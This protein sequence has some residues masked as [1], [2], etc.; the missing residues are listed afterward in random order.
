MYL[1]GQVVH[2]TLIGDEALS[3]SDKDEHCALAQ[4]P[5]EVE[6]LRPAVH[7]M[8]LRAYVGVLVAHV[9]CDVRKCIVVG[10][11]FE[12]AVE[13][14]SDAA[15]MLYPLVEAHL[16]LGILRYGND[17]AADGAWRDDA[18]DGHHLAVGAAEH[19]VDDVA[20]R[21]LGHS[22]GAV[23]KVDDDL[24]AV[25]LLDGMYDAACHVGA[26]A[27]DGG[28]VHV[29]RRRNALGLFEQHLALALLVAAVAC[30]RVVCHGEAH[31]AVGDVGVA[32]EHGKLRNQVYVCRLA[33]GDEALA[34]V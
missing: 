12:M 29:C 11:V 5:L 14:L 9:A 19:V 3:G 27:A 6:Y 34:V 28:H 26:E 33:V 31:E 2:D 15:Y 30:L 4:T 32:Y 7:L 24:S 13:L 17:G 25:V 23:L 21:C 10:M 18:A 16:V 8:V 1:H 22:R 20:E